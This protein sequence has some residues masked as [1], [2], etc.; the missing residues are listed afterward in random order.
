MQGKTFYG[1]ERHR[2]LVNCAKLLYPQVNMNSTAVIFTTAFTAAFNGVTMMEV[3]SISSPVAFL[4]KYGKEMCY[5]GYL[6][7]NDMLFVNT[8][9][10]GMP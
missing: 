6:P 8:R 1:S 2:S 9:V 5:V 4:G 3:C 7:E 10:G